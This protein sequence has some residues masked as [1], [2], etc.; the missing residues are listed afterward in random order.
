M[1]SLLKYSYIIVNLFFLIL[2]VG[3]APENIQ[4]WAEWLRI[5]NNYYV[6]VGLALFG[7]I[8]II[9]TYE[10]PRIVSLWFYL[11]SSER[12]MKPLPK[13]LT[14]IGQSISST[15]GLV[16]AIFIIPWIL[17]GLFSVFFVS[18]W[19]ICFVVAGFDVDVANQLFNSIPF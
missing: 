2:G 11:W 14:N 7:G 15:G 5:L 19:L 9:A 3:G 12:K 16:F 10:W 17:F 18:I 4:Q 6:R 1:K 8:G 13:W